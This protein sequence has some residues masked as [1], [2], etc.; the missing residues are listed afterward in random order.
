MDNIIIVGA[1]HAGVQVADSL[2]AAG[3]AGRLTLLSEEDEAPY[4]RPP[5]SKDFMLGVNPDV[6]LLRG[7]KFF[8]DKDIQLRLG[9]R[10]TGIEPTARRVALQD[11]ATLPYDE[12]ILATGSSNRRFDPGS[13]L[14]PG[15]LHDLRTAKDARALRSRLSD[16][17]HAVIVG[18][19]FVGLNSRRPLARL[20]SA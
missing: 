2:R 15:A 19:G 10:V 4:Q 11:G 20:I 16:A 18:A 9:C 3:Y 1:G 6:L 7:E 8:A 12:L 5:L 14:P 13:E 17:R